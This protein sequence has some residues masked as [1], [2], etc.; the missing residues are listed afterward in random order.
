MAHQRKLIR[1]AIVARL[2]GNTDAGDRVYSNRATALRVLPAILVYTQ[3]ESSRVFDEGPRTLERTAR[4]SIEIAVQFTDE[5]QLDD[6]LDAIADQIETLMHADEQLRDGEGVPLCSDAV[7]TGTEMQVVDDGRQ[8]IG[9]ARL[10]YEVRYYTDA[11]ADENLLPGLERVHFEYELP[12]AEGAADD[13][14]AADDV[15]L[16]Q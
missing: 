3:D 5:E 16:P 7:L 6:R 1:D 11:H 9:A 12:P 8:P 13:P 2:V 14:D 4:I 10:T 15:E